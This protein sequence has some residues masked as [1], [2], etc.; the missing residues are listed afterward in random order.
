MSNELPSFEDALNALILNYEDTDTDPDEITSA[1]E[2][3]LY[4]RQEGE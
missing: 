1:L 4:A 2:V 3:V